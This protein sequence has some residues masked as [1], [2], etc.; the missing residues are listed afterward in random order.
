MPNS[1]CNGLASTE[2][3]KNAGE[4]GLPASLNVAQ[5]SSSGTPHRHAGLGL[6]KLEQR[7]WECRVDLQWR[8]VLVDDQTRLRAYD[9]MTHDDLR[10]WLKGR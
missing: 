1:I 10:A 7:L 4:E 9:I 3:A 8:I 2:P 5:S 6:R